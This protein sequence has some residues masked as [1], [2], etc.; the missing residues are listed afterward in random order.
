M[1]KKKI[2]YKKLLFF[3][4]TLIIVIFGIT[5]AGWCGAQH[6]MNTS[7]ASA[8]AVPS[9]KCR[10][11]LVAGLNDASP[12][13]ADAVLLLGLNMSSQQ[14]TVISFPPN[15]KIGREDKKNMRLSDVYSESGIEG[16][17]SA[18]ENLLHIRISDYAV[19]NY[20]EF[21]NLIDTLGGTDLYVEQDM[22]HESN[23]TPDISLRKGVHMLKGDDALGY[24]RYIG[25]KNDDI[26]RI[27][28]EQRFMKNLYLDHR[29]H[30]GAVNW[31]IMY[32]YWRLA[33]TTITSSEAAHI[34]YRLTY[35]PEDSVRFLIV[36]GET[37]TVDGQTM[38]NVNSV[39]MQKL[40][41]MTINQ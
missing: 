24:M 35:F 15:T 41:G 32:H 18:V 8:S 36:P 22:Y 25:N 39:G 4:L 1:A 17:R 13:S 38:W 3:L 20:D 19:C 34:S 33:E 11:I 12:A 21:R 5:Y 23:G 37:Q 30:I 31:L 9:G 28:R 16:M 10:Y 7:P 2:L 40:I 14:L 6:F 27:Q 29:Q 26:G